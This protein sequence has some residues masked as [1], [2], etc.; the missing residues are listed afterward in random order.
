MTPAG[1]IAITPAA[2]P[3][4][5]AQAK[6]LFL[7]YAASLGFSLCFQGFDRELAEQPGRYAPPSGAL[8]LARVDGALAGCIALR[9]LAEEGACEMKR[10]YVRDAYRGIGLGR[11]LAERVIDVARGKGY[12]RMRLDTLPT[13]VRAIPMYRKLGF[14]EIP[15]YTVNPVEGALFLEKDLRSLS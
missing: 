11:R 15:P 10:L 7:E 12:S 9:A 14:G 4:D 2:A 6:T 5:V 8:L 13:M 1:A 3:E